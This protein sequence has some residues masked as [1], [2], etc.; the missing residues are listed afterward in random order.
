M[1]DATTNSV[2]GIATNKAA[3][4]ISPEIKIEPATTKRRGIRGYLGIGK[5]QRPTLN[6]HCT[7]IACTV[8]TGSSTR[9]SSGSDSLA[10]RLTKEVLAPFSSNRR[11]R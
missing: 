2:C 4:N 1:S 10:M 8:S 9:L 7:A 3:A 6:I 5:I 11:T